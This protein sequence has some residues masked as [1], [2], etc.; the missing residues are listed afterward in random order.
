MHRG[1]ALSLY[2]AVVASDWVDYNGHM[3]DAAYALVF[4]RAGDALMD[5]I[6]LD[7][8]VRKATGRTLYTLQIMLHYLKEASEGAPLFVACQ[9]LEHDDKRMRIWLEMRAGRDGEVIAASEQ[10]LISVDKSAGSKAA[11]WRAETL[12]ALDALAKAHRGLAAPKLAGS[13]ITLKRA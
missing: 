9:L 4:S 2:D 8:A 1:E 3:N 7:A 5:R 11:P 12:A 6:G 13:G 10:L